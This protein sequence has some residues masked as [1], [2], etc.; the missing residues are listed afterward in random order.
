MKFLTVTLLFAL[1]LSSLKPSAQEIA[2]TEK[3]GNTLNMGVG[4]GYYGYVGYAVP[5]LHL[6]YEF[7]V[8]RNFTLAPFI[9][10]YTYQDY[11]YWGDAHNPYQNYSYNQTV[12]PIG[13][14]G[15]YYFDQLLNA[16]PKWDFY[17]AGSLGFVIRTTTWE[18]GYYG[19]TTIN[20]GSGPLYL[21]VHVGTE[22]HFSNKTGVFL[23]L[24]TGIST[25]GLAIHFK[26]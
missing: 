12:V 16:G 4:L 14:K 20:E 2:T 6:N 15:T 26:R 8:A 18:N 23:D 21:D 10:Y 11:Y 24:S 19:E 3:F 9:T 7:D 13:I 5:V 25:I 17:L 22:Y 1:M